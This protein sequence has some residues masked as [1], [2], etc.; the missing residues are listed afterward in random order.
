M[1]LALVVLIATLI[2][3]SPSVLSDVASFQV[4]PP[5]VVYSTAILPSPCAV[6]S[7]SNWTEMLLYPAVLARN[8]APCDP[9]G[10]VLLQP[11]APTI[12]Q[13]WLVELVSELPVSARIAEASGPLTRAIPMLAAVPDPVD[14][15][16]LVFAAAGMA[17]P[18]LSLVSK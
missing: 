1:V 15:S 6:R 8:C 17:V 3:G 4:V 16:G 11:L 18:V 10:A 7:R 9:I 14:G 12:F 13:A 2:P 5:L